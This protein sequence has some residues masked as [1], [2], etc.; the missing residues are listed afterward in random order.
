MAAASAVVMAGAVG[1]FACSG[2]AR[3]HAS[4][5]SSPA[6]SAPIANSH[7]PDGAVSS[8]PVSAGSPPGSPQSPAISDAQLSEID[9]A[10][11]GATGSLGSADQDVTHNEA[12][13]ATP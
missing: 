2:G 11:A 5:A 10:L 12:G 8:N 13:D 3:P 1:L 4:P 6:I 7:Q 9:Q